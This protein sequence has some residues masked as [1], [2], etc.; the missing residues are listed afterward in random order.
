MDELDRSQTMSVPPSIEG[1]PTPEELDRGIRKIWIACIVGS[2]FVPATA[3]AI[4]VAVSLGAVKLSTVGLVAPVLMAVVLMTF[5]LCF[6]IPAGVTSLRRMSTTVRMAYTG[7]Y[8]NQKVSEDLKAMV[9]EA[10]PLIRDLRPI[11]DT[12]RN[13]TQDGFLEK[14]EGHLKAIAD[15]VKRDTQPLPVSKRPVHEE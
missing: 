6:V 9:A 12:I 10:R 14:I 13:Q 3:L 2:T 15:R 7:L 5:G 8:T 4:V 11:V 1:I